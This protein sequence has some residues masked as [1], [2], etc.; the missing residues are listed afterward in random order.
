MNK[1]FLIALA[2]SLVTTG[3][4]A[5]EAG[6]LDAE[7]Y[8]IQPGDV[9]DISV[10]KEKDLQAEVLIRPDGGMSFPLAGDLVAT[11]KSV[12]QL[13]NDLVGRLKTYIP[14]PVVT[15]AVKQIGGNHVY[16]LGKVNRPG[17]FP[18]SRPLD[19]MQALSLAGGTTPYAALN[20]IVILRRQNGRVEAIR[21][22]YGDV[23]RGKDLTQDILLDSGDTVVVP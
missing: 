9:L 5:D 23:E 3:A 21:F 4:F 15:V 13:R 12:E 8:R 20:D 16:V 11:G 6:K 19:V 18:F 10:W 7:H 14:D 2:S 22:H 1:W 17:E